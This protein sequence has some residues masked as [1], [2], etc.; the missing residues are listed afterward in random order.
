MA[1]KPAAATPKTAA[2][3]EADKEPDKAASASAAPD[4][5]TAGEDAPGEAEDPLAIRSGVFSFSDGSIYRAWPCGEA[6]D[7]SMRLIWCP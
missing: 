7:A 2:A 4:G 6:P 5:E 3:K 1:G